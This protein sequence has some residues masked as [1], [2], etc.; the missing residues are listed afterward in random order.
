MLLQLDHP[1][2]TTRDYEGPVVAPVIQAA[3]ENAMKG[4]ENIELD[5]R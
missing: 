2:R 3:I 4:E 5:A 1:T